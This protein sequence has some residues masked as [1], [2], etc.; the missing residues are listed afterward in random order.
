MGRAV[1]DRADAAGRLNFVRNELGP[2]KTGARF[3]RKDTCLAI[4][5]QTV[6][7]QCALSETLSRIT[8]RLNRS[9]TPATPLSDG[10]ARAF[11]QNLLSNKPSSEQLQLAVAA[12]EAAQVDY[13]IELAGAGGF[14]P[15]YAGIKIRA[16]PKISA[17]FRLVCLILVSSSSIAS[18]TH[19][20]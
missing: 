17:A 1:L 15:T 18:A 3:S 16:F 6:N 10:R 19:S 11:G 5:S 8:G 14:E 20:C 13:A 4:Y 9:W 7:A 12:D 2:A